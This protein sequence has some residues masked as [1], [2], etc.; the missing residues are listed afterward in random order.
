MDNNSG[1]FNYRIGDIALTAIHDGC[2]EMPLEGF[3]RNAEL[4]E[5][6]A[7]LAASGLPGDVLRIPFT[8]SVLRANGKTILID[9]SYGEMG[10]PTAGQWMSNFRAAGFDPA[11]VD[12]VIFSH[13]HPDH[14]NL[15]RGKDGST[16]FP[17]AEVMVPAREWQYWMSPDEEQDAPN[18]LKDNFAN[19]HRVFDPIR[20]KVRIFVPGDEIVPGITAID[21]PGH[22]PGH[23]AFSIESTGETLLLMSDTSNQPALFAPRPEFISIFDMDGDRAAASRR[24]MFERAAEAGTQVT[25]FHAAFPATGHLVREGGGFRFVPLDAR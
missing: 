20:D 3:I 15:Y 8:S 18:G 2:F 25:F 13:L 1:Y 23:V 9:T 7:V 11:A 22:T 4:A 24:R 19:V 21:V 17:N 12:V 10:P 6:Q 14:I 16:P 5:V